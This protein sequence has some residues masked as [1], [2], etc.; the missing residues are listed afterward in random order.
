MIFAE[1]KTIVLRHGGHGISYVLISD[2]GVITRVHECTRH[3][4]TELNKM[5]ENIYL[6][7]SRRNVLDQKICPFKLFDSCN[8]REIRRHFEDIFLAKG[9]QVHYFKGSINVL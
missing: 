2:V 3:K 4:T 1:L 5:T 7:S 6:L 8:S 9:K